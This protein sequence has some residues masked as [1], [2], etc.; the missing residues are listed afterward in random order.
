VSEV[1][2]RSAACI[3]VYAA[4]WAISVAVLVRLGGSVVEPIFVLVLL[5]VALPAIAWLATRGAPAPA[6]PIARPG[7]QLGAVILYLSL[8]AVAVLGWLFSFLHDQFPPGRGRDLAILAAKLVT[9]VA[10]P[11]LLLRALGSAPWPRWRWSRRETIALAVAGCALLAFQ[12]VFGRGLKTLSDL[13]PRPFQ[14][15]LGIP[16]ALLWLMVE[17]GLPEEFVFRYALQSR[18]A[19]WLRT[20]TG[21]VLIS[22]AL[23]GL[24]HAPGLHLRGA[25]VAEGFG[26]VPTVS[27]A[28]AYSMAIIS[29]AGIL[30]GVLWWRTRSLP[31]LV[32]LHG[33][34]DL[35]PNLA[36][37]IRT[38]MGT[39]FS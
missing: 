3:A 36:D 18:L 19:A 13:H 5:G 33:L 26:G 25:Q 32:I 17:A 23:F 22:A 30:F 34:G 38:W 9:A 7:L 12:A 20:E 8:F 1:R 6:E 2:A 27:W 37:F 14:L 31:L 35:L 10:A 21:A 39:G 28:V 16:A 4:A 29:P 24:A 11:A 15:A